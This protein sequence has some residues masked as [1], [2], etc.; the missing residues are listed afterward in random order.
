MRTI[1][2]VMDFMTPAQA[3]DV[4][5]GAAA[6]DCSSAFIAAQN[7]SDTVRVPAGIYRLAVTVAILAGKKWRF[8][9]PSLRHSVDNCA[10]FSAT[11]VDG[12]SWLGEVECV[13]MLQ[14]GADT[15]ES[16]LII[17]GCNQW[18]ID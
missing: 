17:I 13:G 18:Y 16:A 6:V 7:A 12:W 1:A 9:S 2:N 15:G 11:D 14:D 5:S 4:I 10:M 8:E 3:A